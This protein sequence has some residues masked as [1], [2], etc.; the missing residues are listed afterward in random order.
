MIVPAGRSGWGGAE[1]ATVRQQS[2]SKSKGC[3]S[4]LAGSYLQIKSNYLQLT[5]G[6][7]VF[8]MS[9]DGLVA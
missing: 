2:K 5:C 3:A 1:P 9:H 4:R 6:K 7:L 8:C